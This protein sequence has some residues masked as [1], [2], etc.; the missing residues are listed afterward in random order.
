[1]TIHRPTFLAALAA[2]ALGAGATHAL[3]GT[4]S[5]TV[6]AVESVPLANPGDQLVT[7]ANEVN[8][9]AWTQIA[10][11]QDF[12]SIQESWVAVYSPRDAVGAALDWNVQVKTAR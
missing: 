10:A 6:E 4:K 3:A 5:P 12:R 1:M 8:L 7:P 9:A 11:S 2:L